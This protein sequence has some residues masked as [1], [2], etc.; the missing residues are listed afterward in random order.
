[1]NP[2]LKKVFKYRRYEAFNTLGNFLTPD[3]HNIDD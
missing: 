3:S 1:M 2:Y